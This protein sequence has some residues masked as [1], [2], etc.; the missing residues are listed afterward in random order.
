MTSES[1]QNDIE[2]ERAEQIKRLMRR[3][4]MLYAQLKERNLSGAL[5]TSREN[6]RYLT[7]FTGTT[8]LTLIAPEGS[9]ILVDSRYIEQA[10]SQCAAS[11]LAVQLIEQNMKTDLYN[12]IK[13]LSLLHIGIEDKDLTVHQYRELLEGVPELEVTGLSDLLSNNRVCKD[14]GEIALLKQAVAIS[15]E[16]WTEL[17]PQIRV[18]MTEIEIAGRLEYLMRQKGAAGP[19]FDTIIGSGYRSALPHGVA[20]EKKIEPGDVIVMDFGCIYG[21]YCSDITR[22]VFVEYID[23]EMG[24]IYDIV[25]AAHKKAKE[26]IKA[27][28]TGKAADA[29]AR[30]VIATSGY[31]DYFG[32]SLGHSIGLLIHESPNFSPAYTG[33][34]PAGAVLSVEPGIYLPGKGGV[35]IEDI[36]IVTEVGYETFTQA[37]QEK[38]VIPCR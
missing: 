22:T 25:L 6:T 2:M 9:T 24:K 32:H 19:S 12:L 1:N 26:G 36:G 8:S 37:S 16:A 34:I 17:L 21:G 38:I 27:G 3:R 31:G 13:G 7:G 33:E 30:E 29:I 28:I 18:G 10:K 14:P 35:R 4:E 15:D 5:L 20:S 23:E 11:D